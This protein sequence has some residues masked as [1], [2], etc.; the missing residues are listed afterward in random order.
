MFESPAFPLASRYLGG[1]VPRR[2]G[3][4]AI[5]LATVGMS[6]C[7]SPSSPDC[8]HLNP[9]HTSQCFDQERSKGERQML[10]RCFPFSPPEKIS[11]LWVVGFEKNDFFEGKA[12]PT[13]SDL[14]KNSGTRLISDDSRP[15]ESG[16]V[17][18]FQV[19]LTGRRSI[20]EFSKID[21]HL[22]IV[23]RITVQ[24]EYSKTP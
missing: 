20:C 13:E 2:I 16:I 6:S 3:L 7:T 9:I 4:A 8:T 1:P 17:K 11:G 22:I 12:A 23:D 10:L 14:S 5:C 19:Q 18:A 24:E 21:P 15:S